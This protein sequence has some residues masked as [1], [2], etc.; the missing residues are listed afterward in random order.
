MLGEAGYATAMAGK[1]HLTGGSGRPTRPGPRPRGFDHHYGI[2][3][4][5][6]SYYDPATLTEDGQPAEAGD[7]YYLTTELRE[8][9]AAISPI[10]PRRGRISRSS[11]T[12]P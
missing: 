12:S 1:W 2:I 11:S 3:A 4:G 6:A 5:A 9:A 8:R 7:D 10:T